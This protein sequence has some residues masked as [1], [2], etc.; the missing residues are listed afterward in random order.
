MKADAV[1]ARTSAVPE[2]VLSTIDRPGAQLA[3][4]DRVAMEESFGQDFAHVRIHTDSLAAR[5][6]KEINAEAYSFG[7]KVVFGRD[8]YRPGDRRSQKVVAHELTHVI[9]QPR[10]QTRPQGIA[11][12]NVPAEHAASNTAGD[13]QHGG[14]GPTHAA[15]ASPGLIHRQAAAGQTPQTPKPPQVQTPAPQAPTPQT[16]Q[17]QTPQAGPGKPAPQPKAQVG[18][19]DTWQDV[20]KEFERARG[21][22]ALLDPGQADNPELATALAREL[23]LMPWPGDELLMEH[24]VELASW[25]QTHNSPGSASLV[26][27]NLQHAS[28]AGKLAPNQAHA[29]A[30]DSLTA[31]KEQDPELLIEQGR[32]AAKAGDHSLAAR[33]L[34]IA[35]QILWL[36]VR[37]VSNADYSGS[38]ELVKDKP[39]GELAGLYRRLR[40]IYSVYPEIEQA[41][42]D[43]RDTQRANESHRYG[44]IL[45]TRLVNEF[46]P[47]DVDPKGDA[48]LAEV[49]LVHKSS[50]DALRLYG[51]NKTTTD[52][53]ELPGLT[54]PAKT[55]N[56]MGG[57]ILAEHI[58]DVQSALMGQVDLQAE[59]GREPEIRKAF[60][61]GA[62]DLNDLSTRLKVW[63]IMFSVYQSTSADPLDALMTLIGKYL[64][65]FTHHTEFNVRDFGENYITSKFPVNVADQAERDCGVY[66]LMVAWD[67]FQTVKHGK[68]PKV[69]FQLDVMLD[70]VILAMNDTSTHRNYIVSNDQ[71]TA[72][73]AGADPGEAVTKAYT[74]VRALPYL[75]SPQITAD[76]GST[77]KSDQAFRDETWETYKKKTAHATQVTKD[78]DVR[79][80]AMNAKLPGGRGAIAGTFEAQEALN[81]A[82]LDLDNQMDDLD[83]LSG[84]AFTEAIDHELVNAAALLT[85]FQMIARSDKGPAPDRPVQAASARPIHPLVRFA[86]LILKVQ[87]QGGHLSSTFPGITHGKS[88][89][90][91][92]TDFVDEVRGFFGS[93]DLPLP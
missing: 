72:V 61:K 85:L 60:P 67:V 74:G 4:T 69:T 3:A 1:H 88:A 45:R 14:A 28:Q 58:G 37:E 34:G 83:K 46:T 32:Q 56:D 81:H 9:Q 62:I 78:L 93:K 77:E 59:L 49:S 31:N 84:S 38:N 86:Q 75:A 43:A 80:A 91:N 5:S 8:I 12:P 57:T 30:S 54:P 70:H 87:S 63:S 17:G 65:A 13:F 35:N 66:A 25:L 89:A 92:A 22:G 7:N 51:T 15:V 29:T 48:E 68:G 53:T 19:G 55:V 90:R 33:Y 16:P 64:K 11:G 71:I 41:A 18:Q 79:F 2:S 26:L 47:K 73:D 27:T 24:G 6:A 39:Y 52:L 20:W 23:A 40:E 44:E 21:M 10:T 42:L 36:Y 76:L 50:G 82:L